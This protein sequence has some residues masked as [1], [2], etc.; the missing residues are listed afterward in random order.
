[1]RKTC[2]ITQ[3]F[4]IIQ[5]FKADFP[6]IVSPKILNYADSYGFF[7]L[8][9]VYLKTI[10]HLNSKLLIFEGTLHVLKFDFQKFRILE[11]LNFH[12]GCKQRVEKLSM[13]SLT[14]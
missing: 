7:G 5:E 4:R 8:T 1:M 9:S 6:H 2:K 10:E 14:R 3:F 13:I 12:P 11:I